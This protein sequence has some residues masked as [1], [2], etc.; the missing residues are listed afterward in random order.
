MLRS[1]CDDI[2][3]HYDRRTRGSGT[4]KISHLW[5]DSSR[6]NAHNALQTTSADS[7]QGNAHKR[8]PQCFA[9]AGKPA[10]QKSIQNRQ[11]SLF[12]S[13][14]HDGLADSYV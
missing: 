3:T 4:L 13:L 14:L 10:H 6:G 9:N 1:E 12:M 11:F 5:I 2:L 8:I 7:S